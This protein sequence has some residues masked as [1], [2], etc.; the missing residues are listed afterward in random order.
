MLTVPFTF[1]ASG[2][3]MPHYVLFLGT[4][5]VMLS[6]EIISPGFMYVYIQFKMYMTEKL[7]YN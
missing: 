1:I 5:S 7:V 2:K 4:N 3:I 6:A